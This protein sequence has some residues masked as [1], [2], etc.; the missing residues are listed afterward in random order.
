MESRGWARRLW[1]KLFRP[2]RAYLGSRGAGQ[3]WERLAGRRLE[4][5][6]YRI[7]TRNF[8]ARAGEIDFVAEEAGV[9]CFIEVKGRSSASR[10]TP[11]EA[12]TLEK[13]RR[14]FRAAEEYLRR[15][16]L[17]ARPCRFDV[18]AILEAEGRTE[19]RVLR[20]AFSKPPGPRRRD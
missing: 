8:R 7:L 2:R 3:R 4:A 14:I 5:L 15:R 16:R 18:V 1:V 12:V 20:S 11:E 13:Q 9:L 19:V 6:G 17:G 10:G